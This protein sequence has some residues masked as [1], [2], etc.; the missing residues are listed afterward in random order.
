[1]LQE[2]ED[3]GDNFGSG[4]TPCKSGILPTAKL[5]NAAT[6]DGSETGKPNI[7][8]YFRSDGVGT[9]GLLYKKGSVRE[10]QAP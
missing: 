6:R 7:S 1:L 4:G 3:N 8:V 9:N 2:L 10:I 5:T